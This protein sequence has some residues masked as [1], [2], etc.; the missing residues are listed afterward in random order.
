MSIEN[1][2]ASCAINKTLGGT[3]IKTAMPPKARVSMCFR[4]E[5]GSNE[6]DESELQPKKHNDPRISTFRGISIDR[7]DDS[8]NAFDSIRIN[9]EFDSNEIDESDLQCEK[10]DDPRISMLPLISIFDD[11]EKLRIN[12]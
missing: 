10:H 4:C 2:A 6:I 12:R 1:G 3:I 8:R 5:S 9:R 7:S 11:D